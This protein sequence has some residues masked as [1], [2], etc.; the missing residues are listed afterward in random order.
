[1]YVVRQVGTG[2]YQVT[3]GSVTGVVRLVGEGDL[4][5]GEAHLLVIPF[6]ASEFEHAK[7]IHNR[8]VK[9]WEG[10]SYAWSLEAATKAG[11]ADLPLA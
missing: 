5:A 11:E 2:R 9:T 10:K 6:G 3:N 4:K 7:V 1:F 8:S